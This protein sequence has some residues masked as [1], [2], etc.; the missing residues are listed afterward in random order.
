[1]GLALHV[2]YWADL[3][4]VSTG[5]T[6]LY[7]CIAPLSNSSCID[8][9]WVNAFQVGNTAVLRNQSI[10]NWF[11]MVVI[12]AWHISLVTYPALLIHNMHFFVIFF[13]T[14]CSVNWNL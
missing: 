13:R 10:I 3:A 12:L 8:G 2:N 11:L 4:Q 9:L 5:Y 1:M 14:V 6:Q 7:Q